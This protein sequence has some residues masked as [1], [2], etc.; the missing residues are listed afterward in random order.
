VLSLINE[1]FSPTHFQPTIRTQN[2]HTLN[3]A[4]YNVHSETESEQCSHYCSTR[5]L[6][7][8][9]VAV[10]EER[11]SDSMRANPFA[12]V[13]PI[14]PPNLAGAPGTRQQALATNVDI[15][16]GCPSRGG[17]AAVE[18][19]SPAVA[20]GAGPADADPPPAMGEDAHTQDGGGYVT[21]VAPDERL[22]QHP[23]AK[24]AAADTRT[25]APGQGANLATVAGPRDGASRVVTR[26]TSAACGSAQT[27]AP[28][29]PRQGPHARRQGSHAGPRAI[30]PGADNGLSPSAVGARAGTPGQGVNQAASAG[31][32]AGV[33][34]RCTPETVYT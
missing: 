3:L 2:A 32:M 26:R 6:V 18:V 22:G 10:R 31:L 30:A 11:M 12:L 27:D 1:T 13:N 7:P 25:R 16:G 8:R 5:P 21:D 29:P 19:P 9:E 23:R 4:L 20:T 17:S 24:S 15:A 28:P 33:F 34:L 14:A